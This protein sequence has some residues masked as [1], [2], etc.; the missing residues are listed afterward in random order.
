[1]SIILGCGW[2]VCVHIC[3]LSSGK[4]SSNYMCLESGRRVFWP[5]CHAPHTRAGKALFNRDTKGG[6]LDA[7][8]I[9]SNFNYRAKWYYGSLSARFQG[10]DARWAKIITKIGGC[11]EKN[12]VFDKWKEMLWGIF[13]NSWVTFWNMAVS[14]F[15]SPDFPL[16]RGSL[17]RVVLFLSSERVFVMGWGLC[18][19]NRFHLY[20]RSQR[21]VENFERRQKR[22]A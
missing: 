16:G 13:I 15:S 11:E 18:W 14:A 8:Q 7:G 19:I 3:Q 5:P 20:K 22:R 17:L 9:E 10:L 6:K 1:M 2:F 12:I 21:A 4:R